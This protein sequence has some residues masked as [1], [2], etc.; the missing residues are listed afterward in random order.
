MGRGRTCST[1][2]NPVNQR[3]TNPCPYF[4]KI[5]PAALPPAA[6]SDVEV[7]GLGVVEDDRRG[8]LLGVELVLLGQLD[9]DPG[10]VK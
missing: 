10:G 7:A 8:R 5:G 2:R 9:A 1:I 3:L 4:E 6:A